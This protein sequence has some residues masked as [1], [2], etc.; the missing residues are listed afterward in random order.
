MEGKEL[1]KIPTKKDPV[2]MVEK[3]TKAMAKA[4]SMKEKA[5]TKE[6]KI[7]ATEADEKAKLMRKQVADAKFDEMHLWATPPKQ[8]QV[9]KRIASWNEKIKKMEMNI[10]HKDDNKE[11]SLGTS[12]VRR[13]T[14]WRVGILYGMP[15]N[16]SVLIFLPVSSCFIYWH[17]LKRF[18]LSTSCA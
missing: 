4:K 10:K 11:V 2:K 3:A 7:A 13:N 18:S 8:D 17:N 16:D 14:V 5:K 15:E 1:D 12:K 9:I 6:E